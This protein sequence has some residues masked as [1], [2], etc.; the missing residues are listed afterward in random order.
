MIAAGYIKAQIA[1]FL[2]DLELV[3]ALAALD[4]VAPNP[5]ALNL[6]ALNPAAL[7]PVVMK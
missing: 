1:P 7:D 5:T 4:Q 3:Q 2:V 6:I